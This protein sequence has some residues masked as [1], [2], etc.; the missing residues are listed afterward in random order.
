MMDNNLPLFLQLSRSDRKAAIEAV[1]FASDEPL[2]LQLMYNILI[3]G[4]FKYI[5]NDKEKSLKSIGIFNEIADDDTDK[6]LANNYNFKPDDFIQYIQE[7]NGELLESGRPYTIINIAG[8]WQ[9]AT[10]TEYGELIQQLIKYKTRRKLSQA[11][12]ET[13]AIIAYKQ[14]VTRLEIEQIRGVGCGEVIN[15]LVEKNLI[16]V[17]GRKDTIGKPL[18]FSTTTEFLKFF[19]IN[20]V[21]DLPKL[22]ELGELP[23]ENDPVLSDLDFAIENSI[24]KSEEMIIE[25]N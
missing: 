4:E 18:L 5:K 21:T 20:D 8:G 25:K 15:S 9:F 1:I 17:T 24:S 16:E 19:R 6:A 10:R 23:S 13:L 3:S 12:L 2:S 11:S 22:K 14:P 7:I